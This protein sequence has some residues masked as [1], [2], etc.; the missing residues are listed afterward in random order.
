M[1]QMKTG[2]SLSVYKE[3][4]MRLLAAAM[5]EGTATL[6][7]PLSED[8]WNS[9][10]TLARQHKVIGLIYDA[11]GKLPETDFPASVR[12]CFRMEAISVCMGQAE[13]TTSFLACLGRM[14]EAGFHPLIVKGLVC[15]LLYPKPDLR[16]SADEDL[17]VPSGEYSGIVSWLRKEGFACIGEDTS[18]EM[19]QEIGLIR[20]KD[21][22]Y[23]EI[24]TQL[25]SSGSDLGVRM[26]GYFRDIFAHSLS[27]VYCGVTYET[28]DATHHLL[29]LLCHY[30]KHFLAGGVGIRQL[31]DIMLFAEK[32]EDSIDWPSLRGWL[33]ELGF[34]AFCGNL[35][36]ICSSWLGFKC[37]GRENGFENTEPSEN[38][39]TLLEDILDAGIYGTSTLERRHSGILTMEAAER[40]TGYLWQRGLLKA[41]FPPVSY[42]RKTYV[43]LNRRPWLLPAAYVRRA[44]SYLG[45]RML[46]PMGKSGLTIGRERMR[47]LAKYGLAGGQRKA[48]KSTTVSGSQFTEKPE[49]RKV[50]TKAYIDMLLSVMDEGRSVSL[51]IAGG[52][53][54][55]FLADGRDRVVLEKPGRRPAV[56]D[57][58]LFRRP[59]GDYV[60]HRIR[61]IEG[62]NYYM[63]GDAQTYIEGP[64]A[65]GQIK[66]LV[67]AAKRKGKIIKKGDFVWDFFEKIWIRMVPFRHLCI[68]GYSLYC[69]IWRNRK[70]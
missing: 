30:I 21:G 6:P 2:G 7:C 50:A 8:D 12:A 16:P 1:T 62:E 5:R 52:S 53:M 56:G 27:A 25:F 54:T 41:L 10:L 17:L 69:R 47:L 14:R 37:S 67:T 28:I 60:L 44:G 20:K 33:S 51:V 39:Q 13:R 68:K 15:R 3:A 29:Y 59:D 31:C 32:N 48:K 35:M 24:H 9:I 57:I 46:H 61:K 42:M 43:S 40:Q 4:F 70:K 63:V 18:S 26:N 23:L 66:A 11:A 36:H 45:K 65:K 49:V 38:V 34:D 64:V 58:V 22:L 55:P 19:P